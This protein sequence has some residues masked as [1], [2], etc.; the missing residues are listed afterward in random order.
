M[1]R[2]VQIIDACP[3][4]LAGL[5]DK[6]VA[7]LQYYSQGRR[8]ECARFRIASVELISEKLMVV[9]K[10]TSKDDEQDAGREYEIGDRAAITA[11]RAWIAEL[12]R[13]GEAAP[14]MPLLRRINKRDALSGQ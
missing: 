14:R 6:V 8:R 9:R 4:S 2:V 10:R 7:Y 12:T 3:D 11:I 1:A 5:R 13:L